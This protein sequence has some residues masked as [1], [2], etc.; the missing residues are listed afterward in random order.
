MAKREAAFYRTKQQYGEKTA[1]RE[2]STDKSRLTD[3]NNRSFPQDLSRWHCK[4]E[5]W[6]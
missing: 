2:F 3:L 5:T 1:K 4:E 6:F